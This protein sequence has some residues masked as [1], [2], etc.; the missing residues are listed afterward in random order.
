MPRPFWLVH[1]SEGDY[2]TQEYNSIE[3]VNLNVQEFADGL[4]GVYPKNRTKD[5]SFGLKC[6]LFF[7][8]KK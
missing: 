8:R 1:I 5:K 6:N 3:S 7:G 2:V 4:F